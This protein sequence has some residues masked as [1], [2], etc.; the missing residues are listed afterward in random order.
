MGLAPV[1]V[2][3]ALVAALAVLCGAYVFAIY[4]HS[5]QMKDMHAQYMHEMRVYNLFLL[6]RT[7]TEYTNAAKGLMEA[8]ARRRAGAPPLPT[9]IIRERFGGVPEE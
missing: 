7:S 3:W 5:R 8:E 6:S 1:F 4:A 9:D 2:D